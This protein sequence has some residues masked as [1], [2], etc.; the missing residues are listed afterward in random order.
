MS[1]IKTAKVEAVE[2]DIVVVAVVGAEVAV[3]VAVP[4]R[5]SVVLAKAQII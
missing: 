5:K 3:E 2:E 4:S 1:D